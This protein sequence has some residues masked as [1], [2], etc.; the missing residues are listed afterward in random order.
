VSSVFLATLFLSFA[1]FAGCSLQR[2]ATGCAS[3]VSD[4]TGR[5]VSAPVDAGDAA[6]V[7]VV[8]NDA[9]IDAGLDAFVETPDTGPVDVDAGPPD[10]DV[11]IVD[12]GPSPFDAGP[13]PF[14]AGTD[15]GPPPF[16]AGTDAGPPDAGPPSPALIIRMSGATAGTGFAYRIIWNRIPPL[17]PEVRGWYFD[18][19]DG[20]PRMVDAT[21][22]ECTVYHADLSSARKFQYFPWDTASGSTHT[23]M[24]T[25]FACPGSYTVTFDGVVAEPITT[26]A[27]AFDANNDGFGNA[28]DGAALNIDSLP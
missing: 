6:D 8:V 15:S 4:D 1:S 27:D 16:D 21:T 22:V 10:A 25:R 11:M 26:R 24:C 23:S 19:C 7:A 2:E 5:C 28:G 14:D 12:A 17:S 20:G 9:E 18:G 3:G 13:P